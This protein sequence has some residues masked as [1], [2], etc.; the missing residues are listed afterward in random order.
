MD[1]A[2]YGEV[3]IFILLWAGI[4][5]LLGNGVDGA[6]NMASKR[7]EGGFVEKN[8]RVVKMAF[9]FGLVILATILVFTLTTYHGFREASGVHHESL[10]FQG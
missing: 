1:P 2:L 4:W 7:W 9:Y 8:P 3:I 5:E 6:I 10:L